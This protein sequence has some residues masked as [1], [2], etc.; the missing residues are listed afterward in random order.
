MQGDQI[1]RIF[2]YWVIVYVGQFYAKISQ[3]VVKILENF[4]HGKSNLLILAKSALGYI[5]GDIFSNS[6]GHPAWML[7]HF[8][9]M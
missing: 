5:L 4:F 7:R 2:A 3:Y 9:S 6:S 1:G 8:N